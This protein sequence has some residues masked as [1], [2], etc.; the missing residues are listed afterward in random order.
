MCAVTL[1]TL[2]IAGVGAAGVG[3]GAYEASNAASAQ[4]QALQNQQTALGMEQTLFGEQ[5]GYE[6]QLQQLIANPSSVTTLPGYQF[7][8]NQAEVGVGRAFGSAPGTTGYDAAAQVGAGVAGQF[9]NQQ[10]TLLAQL[11]G[12][13]TSPA[14]MTGAASGATQAATGANTAAANTTSGLLNSI[15]YMANGW[16]TAGLFGGGAGSGGGGGYVD[17]AAGSSVPSGYFSTPNYVPQY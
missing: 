8:L 16:N 9:Y 17:T 11:A 15:M 7:E 2:I 3:V 10:A 4:G 14:A 1:G 6:A 5:Q 13:T 12:I